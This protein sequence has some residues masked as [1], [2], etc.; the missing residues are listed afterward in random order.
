M[1]EEIEMVL[2]DHDLV[3]VPSP[4][5]EAALTIAAA[6]EQDLQNEALS[7]ESELA[8]VTVVSP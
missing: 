6:L 3:R 4:T 8:V 5:L 1:M 7:I 2:R